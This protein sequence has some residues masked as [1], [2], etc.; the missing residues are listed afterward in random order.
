MKIIKILYEIM[1][2]VMIW[3]INVAGNMIKIGFKI[4][5]KIIQIL[6]KLMLL[7]MK[8]IMMILLKIK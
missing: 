3:L 8:M 4:G 2:K 1:M 7:K 6:L 5:T